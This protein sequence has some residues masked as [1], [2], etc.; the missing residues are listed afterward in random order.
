M[1]FYFF[2]SWSRPMGKPDFQILANRNP[3]FYYIFDPYLDNRFKRCQMV[4]E[5][6]ETKN[7]DILDKILHHRQKSLS[8]KVKLTLFASSPSESEASSVF[9]IPSILSSDSSSSP[10]RSSSS[11]SSFSSPSSKSAGLLFTLLHSARSVSSFPLPFFFA[12]KFARNSSLSLSSY[13]CHVLLCRRRGW[14]YLCRT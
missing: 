3:L 7:T 14:S 5:W 1:L 13:S 4:N 12:W 6:T 10:S 8:F 2:N 11:S 9:S